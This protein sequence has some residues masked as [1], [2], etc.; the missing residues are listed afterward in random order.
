M[1]LNLPAVLEVTLGRQSRGTRPWSGQ[2]ELPLRIITG[3]W[4]QSSD[5]GAS[6]LALIS[7]GRVNWSSKQRVLL[8]PQNGDLSPPFLKEKT[9]YCR[10]KQKANQWPIRRGLADAGY[11]PVWTS[12]V[13]RSS[14]IWTWKSLS[15]ARPTSSSGIRSVEY[16]RWPQKKLKSILKRTTVQLTP[17]LMGLGL[18]Y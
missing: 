9:S 5:G 17:F 10:L 8:A 7:K 4:E 6:S 3:E 2:S 14:N 12:C 18:G 16:D 13:F 15:S 11:S 1:G